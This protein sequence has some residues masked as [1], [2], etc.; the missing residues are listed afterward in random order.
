[1]KFPLQ[2]VFGL[3]IARIRHLRK[4]L[5]VVGNQYTKIINKAKV[6]PINE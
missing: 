2:I 6:T 5:F 4:G 1:M 3:Y